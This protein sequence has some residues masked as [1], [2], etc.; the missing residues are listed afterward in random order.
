MM[1]QYQAGKVGSLLV[2]NRRFQLASLI[3]EKVAVEMNH[4]PEAASK[5]T[6]GSVTRSIDE[7]VVHADASKLANG[8]P[9]VS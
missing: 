5:R 9:A 3:G 7:L 6:L 2:E 8:A 4:L 1:R